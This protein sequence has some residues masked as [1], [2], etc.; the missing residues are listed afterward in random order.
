V[1]K[2]GWTTYVG[3]GKR[4]IDKLHG[5]PSMISYEIKPPIDKT[6]GSENSFGR[7][8]AMHWCRLGR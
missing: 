6:H 1:S 4:Q 8:K 2:L 3:P 7:V 5:L